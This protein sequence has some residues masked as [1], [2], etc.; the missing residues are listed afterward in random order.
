MIAIT[1]SALTQIG[2]AAGIPAA[3]PI[4]VNVIA[5]ESIGKNA[6]M[7]GDRLYR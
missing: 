4:C 2:P 5:G 6:G 7:I 3:G 1:Q